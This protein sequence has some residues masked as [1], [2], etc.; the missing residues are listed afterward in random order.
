MNSRKSIIAN[1]KA[2]KNINKLDD[3]NSAKISN[4]APGRLAEP[5]NAIDQPRTAA[6]IGGCSCGKGRRTRKRRM[7]GGRAL[8]DKYG[9]YVYVPNLIM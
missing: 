3:L 5:G 2:I 7:Q 1:I 9:Q 4:Q 6:Q 8:R